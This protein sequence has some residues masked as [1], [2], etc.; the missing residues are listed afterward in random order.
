MRVGIVGTLV[1]LAAICPAAASPQTD[2]NQSSAENQSPSTQF[3]IT[4]TVVDGV[5]SVPLAKANVF[6]SPTSDRSRRLSTSSAT[7]GR[8]VF[9]DLPPGKYVLSGSAKGYPLRMFQQ[10]ETFTTGVAVGKDLV[11]EN[12]ILE[13]FPL[14]S[15]SGQV[16]DEFSDPVRN[17]QVMLLR[18]GTNGSANLRTER[19]ATTDDQGHYRFAGLQAERYYIAVSAQPWYAQHNVQTDLAPSVAPGAPEAARLRPG[20][21]QNADLDVAYPITYSPRETD[22]AKATP[23]ALQPGEQATADVTLAPVRALRLRLTAP[24]GID[25][26]QN[27]GVSLTESVPGAPPG[28][29]RAQVMN[30]NKDFVDIVGVVPGNFVV[31]LNINANASPNER[32]TLRQEITVSRGGEVALAELNPPAKIRGEVR[33]PAQAGTLQRAGIGIRNRNTGATFSTAISPD[34]KFDFREALL[35]AGLY[36][37]TLLGA[38]G[39]YVDHV[40]SAGAKT[41]GRSFEVQGTNAVNLTI[42][43]VPGVAQVEGVAQREG[44][45]VAGAMILLVPRDFAGDSLSL[46]RDQSDGDGTF[47]L[48]QVPPG[49]YTVVAVENGWDQEWSNPAVVKAWLPFGETIDVSPNAKNTVTVKVQ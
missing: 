21:E 35:N 41:S 42:Y 13:L 32:Q 23:I 46:R 19:Q 3:R 15:I 29:G 45:P 37:L 12:L 26:S 30:V 28:F 24:P 20:L 38:P 40:E 36:D 14:G 34:A 31:S 9:S 7:D 49:A 39:F 17:A 8:F 27:V 1:L 47:T 25:L 5:T 44:K 10:H 18:S 16:N 48:P 6:I 4:G 22:A 33:V 43:V 11:S 2:A